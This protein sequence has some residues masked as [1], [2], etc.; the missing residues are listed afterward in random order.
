[1]TSTATTWID[2][3]GVVNMRDVGGIPT[4][5]GGAIRRGALL[6]SD[7]LQD[8]TPRDVA[9]LRERGLT[10]V[11]D[12]RSDTEVAA[13]GPGPLTREPWVRIHHHSFF[14]ERDLD[15]DGVPETSAP[16]PGPEP[17]PT[18]PDPA[19]A[20]VPAEALPWV[21]LQPSTEH[22]NPATAHYLSY[23]SDRPDSVVAGLRVVAEAEGAVL[24]HCAAGKDRT[25][26]LVALAL[27]L[28][29]AEPEAVVADYAASSERVEQI[30]DR[31][32]STPTYAAVLGGQPAS[33]HMTHPET[34]ASFIEH[35]QP[36]GDQS[37]LRALLAR[38]GWTDAD[39][40]RLRAR[41]RG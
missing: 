2:L 38:Y 7:N 35:V 39:A 41:L 19:A 24:V 1:M 27:L 29:G 26:T 23:L 6:R 12:L 16:G 25:G 32:V 14:D 8:L 28:A 11:V 30:L 33:W 5:D 20:Q 10:D 17:A 4:T 22:D 37:R 40:E 15:R 31:L 9:A 3:D 21:G 13:T 36:G 18:E 34:M